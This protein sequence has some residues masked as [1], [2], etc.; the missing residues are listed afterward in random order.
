MLCKS[1][2][3]PLLNLESVELTRILWVHE[4]LVLQ[5]DAK[6]PVLI[7]SSRLPYID[8]YCGS[9]IY[10]ALYCAEMA[11]VNQHHLWIHRLARIHSVHL[12]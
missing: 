8:T 10:T 2:L 5:Q 7:Q 11:K 9:Y 12:S 1:R 3:A 6:E 4:D